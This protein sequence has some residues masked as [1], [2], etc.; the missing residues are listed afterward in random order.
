MLGGYDWVKWFSQFAAFIRLHRSPLS[1]QTFRSEREIIPIAITFIAWKLNCHKKKILSKYSEQWAEKLIPRAY[2]SSSDFSF[3]WIRKLQF[4]IQ[5]SLEWFPAIFYGFSMKKM[6]L[7]ELHIHLLH[8]IQSDLGGLTL[9]AK[10]WITQ[11]TSCTINW[12]IILQNHTLIVTA[13]F[14]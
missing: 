13:F 3:E 12:C 6:W 14:V 8:I 1:A 4:L 9:R 5:V 7:M 11:S 10:K 2:E